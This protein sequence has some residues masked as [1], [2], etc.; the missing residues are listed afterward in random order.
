MTRGKEYYKDEIIQ[1]CPVDVVVASNTA[2]L[3][4]PYRLGHVDES[5]SGISERSQRY[6]MDSKIGDGSKTNQDV[7]EAAERTDADW[8]VP[9]DVVG[10][11]EKTVGKTVEMF[12]QWYEYDVDA[13]IVVPLQSDD[14]YTRVDHFELVADKL[15][16]I[17]V[18]VRDCPVAIGGVMEKT[19]YEQIQTAMDVRRGIGDDVYIHLFGGGCSLPW[20]VTIREYPHLIDGLDMSSIVTEVVQAGRLVT[21]SFDRV[22]FTSPRGTNSTVLT[23]MLREH[24]LYMLNYLMGPDIREEDAPSREELS[25]EMVEL[26]NSYEDAERA[27]V[28]EA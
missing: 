6:I 15:D 14:A 10:D 20:V 11:V 25:V 24:Q 26:L 17:G 22:E 8:V 21:P 23:T 28:A 16:A 5:S 7:L 2:M 18:D 19:P 12:L 3:E 9:C 27:A 13:D 1:N 4:Y